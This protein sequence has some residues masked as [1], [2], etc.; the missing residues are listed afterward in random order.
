MTKK[1]MAPSKPKTPPVDAP[2]RSRLLQWVKDTKSIEVTDKEFKHFRSD[3]LAMNDNDA[4]F[5]WAN[6]HKKSVHDY[7]ELGRPKDR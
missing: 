3:L 2:W 4:K 7:I 5:L 1:R 6:R